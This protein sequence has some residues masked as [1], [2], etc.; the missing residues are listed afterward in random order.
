MKVSSGL[1]PPQHRGSIGPQLVDELPVRRALAARDSQ[2]LRCVGNGK[3]DPAGLQQLE[4]FLPNRP[5]V[6]RAHGIARRA[7]STG[8]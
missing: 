6:D 3:G 2:D 4:R 5:G 1:L 8:L 7:K